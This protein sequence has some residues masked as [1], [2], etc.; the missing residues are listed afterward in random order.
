MAYRFYCYLFLAFTFSLCACNTAE[1]AHA[2][3]ATTAK[4]QA[5]KKS[6]PPASESQQKAEPTPLK[7]AGIFSDH[8]VLQRDVALPVWGTA[9]PGSLIAL[10][11]GDQQVP[12]VADSQGNWRAELAPLEVARDLT[13]SVTAG[14]QSITLTDVA[15]G[16]VWFCS[17][18]SN[19]QWRL[20]NTD[21]GKEAVAAAKHADIRLMQTPAVAVDTPQHLL[22]LP[23]W[24]RCTPEGAKDFSAVGYFFGRELSEK[25]DVPI[26]L[27]NSSWGGTPMEA[28]TSRE[29]LAS[30]ETFRSLAQDEYFKGQ[31]KKYRAKDKPSYLYNGKVSH[32]IP[33]AIRGV[34]WYQGE[35][36]ASR[37]GQYRELSELMIADWRHR[38]GL[39]DFPFLFVQLAAWEPGKTWPE[40]R[41]AQ[42]ETLEVHNTG[43]AVTTDIGNR[44]DIHP[45][46]KQDVGYRLSL[47]AR[48]IAYGET[49]EY[50]GPKFRSMEI[51]GSKITLSFSHLGG[52]LKIGE[53]RNGEPDTSA[54]KLTGFEIAGVDGDFKQAEAEIV[55]NQV[56]VHSEAVQEPVAVRYNWTGF[57]TGN[58]FNEAGLPAFSFRTS[59]F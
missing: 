28:W 38:W 39:G 51:D 57:T 17:G 47:A 23:S 36:N 56:V 41:E 50:S 45:R 15:V 46:N 21:N 14:E 30:S 24:Q 52:G 11:V 55:D 9:E 25:L 19:M 49:I 4:P 2:Q 54:G 42:T 32:I 26:G 13:L 8:M 16:E 37:A 44:K 12:A 59:Q 43:M 34:I 31:P 20:S 18:Q 6:K 1:L 3:A 53:L 48:A 27:I 10:K 22:D 40:L 35:A 29:A 5:K 7:L 33:F 58:L